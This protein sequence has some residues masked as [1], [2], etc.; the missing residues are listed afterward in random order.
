MEM[1]AGESELRLGPSFEH[2]LHRLMK[3]RDA[4]L[5]RHAKGGEF[6]PRKAAAGAPIDPATGQHV[7]QCHLLG[8]AQRMVERGERDRRADAQTLGPRGGQRPDH[9][10]GRTDAEAAEVMLG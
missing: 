1:L 9:M 4:L 7:E 8:K 2:D 5:R 3:A 6:D 10:H